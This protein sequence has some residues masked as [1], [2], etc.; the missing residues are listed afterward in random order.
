[1]G[2]S[3]ALDFDAAVAQLQSSA[4]APSGTHVATSQSDDVL[5]A[6]LPASR[7]EESR[8]LLGSS[9]KII[10]NLMS[11]LRDPL[12]FHETLGE[13]AI[14]IL[15]NLCVRSPINQAR[16]ADCG[17]HTLVIDSLASAFATDNA[18]RRIENDAA[19]STKG[20]VHSRLY[21]PFYGFAVEF[22]VNF[23]TCNEQNAELVWAAS[24]PNLFDRLLQCDNAAAGAG[25]GALVHNCIVAAPHRLPDLVAFFPS[26]DESDGLERST[27][28]HTFVSIM[29][30]ED[31]T[32]KEEERF[33]WSFHIIRRLVRASMLRVCFEALGFPLDEIITSSHKD[34]SK[35]Q[36]TFLHIVDAG[37][38][39]SAETSSNLEIE[40]F[41]VP[42][43]SL[44]FFGDLLEGAV[45]KK[46]GVLLRVVA[47]AIGSTVIIT[48]NSAALDNLRQRTVKVAVTVLQMIALHEH[49]SGDGTEV[50]TSNGSRIKVE[51]LALSEQEL[52]GLKGTM[53]RAVA[54]C[55]DECLTAQDQVRKLHGIPV[56][57]N[58]L[59]YERDVTVNPFLRE[60]A[61]L[62]V[63][64]LTLGNEENAREISSLEFIGLQN[65][66]LLE[67]A[68]L[69][70]FMDPKTG[71][72]RLRQKQPM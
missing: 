72:P 64:N 50:I 33:S 6:V 70:A 63:R 16:V 26:L 46:D 19:G 71:R 62:A 4:W 36:Y 61:V 59:A 14:R 60:W 52:Y 45:L 38:S 69:E 3:G 47:S 12:S 37:A 22:L 40:L 35:L 55:C 7:K 18:S 43:N 15:R 5:R 54:V 1:M 21:I 31:G 42:D 17:A 58:A 11:V 29:N 49:P 57:L 68:G 25:A 32:E 34:F 41:A 65:Q 56:I 48:D 13:L 44:G 20:T 10:T 24:F 30:D 8:V 67:K 28:L 51:D 53:V 66:E 39:K 9:S 23:V 27:L 2:G